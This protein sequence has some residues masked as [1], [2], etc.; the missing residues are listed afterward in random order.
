MKGK[1]EKD[2]AAHSIQW[3][4]RGCRGGHAPA[5]W[6]YG[7]TQMN[8]DVFSPILSLHLCPSASIGVQYTRENLQ[9]QTI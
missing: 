8:A 9:T 1:G 4:F 6:N 2:Q 3:R 5:E 7:W